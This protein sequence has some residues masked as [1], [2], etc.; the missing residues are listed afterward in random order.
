MVVDPCRGAVCM[1][2]DTVASADAGNLVV[3]PKSKAG[4]RR[5][6]WQELRRKKEKGPG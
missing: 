5:E 3:A 2:V 4:G 6:L 1:L